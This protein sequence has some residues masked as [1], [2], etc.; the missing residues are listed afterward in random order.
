MGAKVLMKTELSFLLELFLD[1]EV[2]AD[3]KKKVAKRIKEVEEGF[4]TPKTQLISAPNN[5]QHNVPLIVNSPVVAQQ[6]PSMQRL[7]AQN[8]DLIPAVVTA[9]AITTP[10]TPAAAQALLARQNAIRSGRS[11]KPEPGRTSPRKF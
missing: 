5:H 11:E 7:M 2:P 1:D 6:S 10:E 4:L 3:T 8:P 9:P